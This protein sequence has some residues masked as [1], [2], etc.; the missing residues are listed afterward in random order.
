LSIKR[1]FKSCIGGCGKQAVIWSHGQCK[2]CWIKNNP[3]KKKVRSKKVTKPISETGKHRNA[4]YKKA[5][6]EFLD[7]KDHCEVGLP[8]C[9]LPYPAYNS[10]EYLTVH[11]KRG[12]TGDLLVNKDY[13]LACCLNCHRYIEDH[14]AVAIEN[15]WSISRFKD[16]SNGKN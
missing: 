2:A 15:G 7:T 8:D 9:L 16:N 10:G 4:E 12:R 14:P 11:H 13:F 6:L 3:P 1:K 5:R